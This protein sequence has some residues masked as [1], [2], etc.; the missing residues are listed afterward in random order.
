MMKLVAVRSSLNFT[1]MSSTTMLLA[2]LMT[3]ERMREDVEYRVTMWEVEILQ[4]LI[5]YF[6]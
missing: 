3:P 6:F 4:P 2:R 1:N 5:L